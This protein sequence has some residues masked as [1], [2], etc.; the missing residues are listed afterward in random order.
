MEVPHDDQVTVDS[1]QQ[2]KL[3]HCFSDVKNC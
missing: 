3:G 1:I 2:T